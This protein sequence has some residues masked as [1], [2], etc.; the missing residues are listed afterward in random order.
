VHLVGPG[1][2]VEFINVSREALTHDRS[3]PAKA[4]D[5]QVDCH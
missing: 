2:L 5:L 3:C 1:E 4:R